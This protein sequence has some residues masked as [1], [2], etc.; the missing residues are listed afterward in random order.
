MANNIENLVLLTTLIFL[1]APV[2]LLSYV[3]VYNRRKKK[4]AEE[5]ENLRSNFQK[6]LLKTQLEVQEQTLLNV[7]RELHDNIGQVLSFVKLNLG[8]AEGL[9]DQEKQLKINESRDLLAQSITD[10]RHLSKSISSEHIV[11]FGLVKTITKEV[12]RV[13]K[14]GLIAI[15]LHI[16]GEEYTLG[17]HRE[18]VLFRIF[19]ETLNNTLKHSGAKHLKI[20]LQYSDQLFNL[21]LEDDGHGF[22]I[23]AARKK[24]GSGLKNLENR[25]ALIGAVATINSSPGKGCYIMVTLHPLNQQLY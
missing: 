19:Q 13:N 17:E 2:F 18:L 16:K 11:E 24:S 21:T 25:A 8:L 22:L 12:E 5:K 1:L 20:K 6:E 23:G 14:S 9:S 3:I 4:H 15:D 10:L 7:S